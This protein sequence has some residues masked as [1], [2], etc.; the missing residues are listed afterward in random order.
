MKPRP[1][2]SLVAALLMFG[3]LLALLHVRDPLFSLL[4]ISNPVVARNYSLAVLTALWLAGAM[5]V[6]H[7]VEML[8]WDLLLARALNSPVP[9]ALKALGG[10][11]I[12]LI[13]VTCIVGLVFDRS[14]TGFLAALGAGSFALGLGACAVSSRISLPGSAVNLD[15]TF[16]IGDW[17]ELSTSGNRHDDDRPDR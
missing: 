7:L 6:S 9:G 1:I 5:I 16:R 12:F 13:T 11:V 2:A 10:I 3:A 17:I 4:H 14:V 15:R 8:V